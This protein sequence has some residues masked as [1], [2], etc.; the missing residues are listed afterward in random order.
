MHQKQ[1]IV[2]FGLNLPDLSK[3]QLSIPS[4]H[5]E[6]AWP[7][8]GAVIWLGL[9]YVFAMKQQEWRKALVPNLLRL[10]GTTKKG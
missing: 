3:F 7:S 10:A 9:G 1:L 8:R 6:P 2:S 4:L 5:Q